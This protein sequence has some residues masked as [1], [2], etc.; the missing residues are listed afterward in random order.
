MKDFIFTT[1]YSCPPLHPPHLHDLLSRDEDRATGTG[2]RMKDSVFTTNISSEVRRAARSF[3]EVSRFLKNVAPTP[4]DSCEKVDLTRL[5][6]IPLKES[7][8]PYR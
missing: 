6:A 8:Q 2:E 5:L 1:G 3:L 7:A 4:G